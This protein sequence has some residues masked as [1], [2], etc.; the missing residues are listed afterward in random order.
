[1]DYAG[2]RII[3]ADLEQILYIGL[4]SNTPDDGLNHWVMA[5][6]EMA[7]LF[8]SCPRLSQVSLAMPDV[9]LRKV[10]NDCYG[11]YQCALV[12]LFHHL[13]HVTQH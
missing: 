13:L 6:P 1:M 12:R 8:S 11:E 10:D 3:Y 9:S 2:L 7:K 4:G 5:A